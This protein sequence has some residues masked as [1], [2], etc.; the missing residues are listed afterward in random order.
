MYARRAVAVQRLHG[1]GG[2]AQGLAVS[3]RS[4][5]CLP[6]LTR[7]TFSALLER[8]AIRQSITITLHFLR[9]CM[10]L[11]LFE[12]QVSR[13][14]PFRDRVIDKLPIT[15]VPCGLTVSTP[16]SYRDFHPEP[17]KTKL[18]TFALLVT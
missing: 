7:R 15:R 5:A 3:R 13:T 14:F 11:R 12:M 4:V 2:W 18:L 9:W 10:P 17:P 16:R 1:A 8:V 6:A